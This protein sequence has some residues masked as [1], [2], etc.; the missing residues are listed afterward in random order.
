MR[1]RI[2]FLLLCLFITA[3]SKASGHSSKAGVAIIDS[4][5]ADAKDVSTMDGII[6]A[7]YNVISGGAGEKRNWDRMRTLFITEA[8]MIPTGKRPDGSYSKR[9]MSVE[10]YINTSGPYLEKN[11]FFEKEISRKTDQYGQIVQLFSTY[12]SRHTATD[13]KPF[14]RGINSI[15]LFNDGKRW[16]IVSIMW[17]GETT[18]SPIPDRYLK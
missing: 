16:W 13:E 3:A 18:E 1:T 9:V 14:V 15:Q 2:L 11:G 8:R 4:I 6:A 17:Q 12:E 10:D 7:L 5:P